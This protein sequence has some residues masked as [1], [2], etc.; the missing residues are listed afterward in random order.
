LKIVIFYTPLHLT[1]PLRGPRRNIAISFGTE[2]LEWWGY[3]RWWNNFE[4]I[5]NRFDSIPACACD[6]Q[7]T[8]RGTDIHLATA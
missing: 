3:T 8:D 1:P 4:D 6:R 7:T 5:Y 2:K